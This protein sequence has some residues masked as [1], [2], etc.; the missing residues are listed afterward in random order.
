MAHSHPLR[1]LILD[2][3]NVLTRDQREHWLEA[4]AALANAPRDQF[5]EAYWAHRHAYARRP[6]G[7]RLLAPRRARG[8]ARSGRSDDRPARGAST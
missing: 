8:R 3:G 5:I 4:M 1:A 2:Y 6:L 7:A